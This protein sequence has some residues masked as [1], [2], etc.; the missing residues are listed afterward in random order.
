M[1]LTGEFE[2]ERPRLTRIAARVLGDPAE[3]EDAVQQA[4]LR[5][6]RTDVTAVD[7]LPGWLTTV[8]TRVCLD[9]LKAAVPAPHEPPDRAGVDPGPAE[10]VA[11]ADSVGSALHLVLDRLTPAER[12]A[13]V[14]HDSF[15]V[16]FATIAG[17]LD[18]TPV[19]ARKH[20]SRARS[21][22]AAP[23]DGHGSVD[24][25]VVD[26]FLSAARDGEFSRLLE[27]LAPG[28]VVAGDPVAVGLG[29]PARIEGRDAVAEFFDGA[30]AAALPV[31]VLGR[32]GAAWFDR[33]VARVAFDFRVSAGLVTR[34]DFRAEPEALET[35]DRRRDG[36]RR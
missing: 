17:I 31:F 32:P 24:W 14:L 1:D 15:A 35:I 6:A 11:L 5:L 25:Q 2:H 7:N 8:V 10:E 18:C 21:K 26:A 12:V 29:T 28:V 9:R 3:A 13:L 22:V 27:L 23:P 4:W 33:G 30:A 19:A 34:I 20:A 16:D 36:D